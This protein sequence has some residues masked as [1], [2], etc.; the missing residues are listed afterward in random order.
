[1][2][3]PWLRRLRLSQLT[4][5][6]WQA[7]VLLSMGGMVLAGALIGSVLLDRTDDMS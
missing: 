2:T 3:P 6:G 4:V 7:L 5:R 1:M